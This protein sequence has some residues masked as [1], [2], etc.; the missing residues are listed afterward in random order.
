MTRTVVDV[1]SNSVLALVATQESSGW[2][3]IFESSAVT[4]LGTGTKLTGLL[5]ESS[6]AATLLALAEAKQ[7]SD[8]HGATEWIAAATMAA[9]IATNSH[10]FLDRA[11]AQGTPV[12]ILSGEDEA[13]LGF[14]AV[15]EDPLFAGSDRISIVDPGGQSTEM[16]T[17]DRFWHQPAG[18][19][20]A[21]PQWKIGFRKSF[22]VGALGLRENTL[23]EES[24]NF[25]ARMRASGEIDDLLSFA[26]RPN[27]C[28]T[29]VALGATGT[30]LITIRE[31]MTTWQPDRVHGAV[32]EYEEISRA[33]NWLMD[34]TDEERAAVPG[35][36]RGRERT[37]HIG[38]LILERFLF[39]LRAE[40]CVV[41]TRG[42][43]HALLAQGPAFIR[44]NQ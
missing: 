43:R 25:M 42:W 19:V 39:A 7:V 35:M 17:A 16:V 36:E 18:A 12:T 32:L 6:M 5:A 4:G 1:G 13:E 9:R 40:K 23:A 38:A 20:E 10:E 24:P 2:R 3:T 26:Y 33:A 28:G 27:E 34:M 37:I 29:V 31:Q 8:S 30:N 41:S 21:S 14:L 11:A 44:S 15:S 22:P